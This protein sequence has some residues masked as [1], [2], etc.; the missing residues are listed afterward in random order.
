MLTSAARHQALVRTPAAVLVEVYRGHRADAAVNRVLRAAA[1]AVNTTTRIARIAGVLLARHRRSS[2]DAVGALVVATAVHLGGAI[3][4][5]HDP[6]DFRALAVD[7][8]NIKIV[9][10]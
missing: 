9:P 4:A 8:P 6:K 7:H 2:R 3:I 10:F 1:P 5:T